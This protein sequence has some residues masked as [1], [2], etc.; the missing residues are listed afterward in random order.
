MTPERTNGVYPVTVNIS[1][2]DATGTPI[3]CIYTIYV[4]ITDGKSGEITSISPETATA[5]PPK[6]SMAYSIALGQP[7]LLIHIKNILP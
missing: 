3:D 1:G 6:I 7:H 2:Y 4:T 5:E